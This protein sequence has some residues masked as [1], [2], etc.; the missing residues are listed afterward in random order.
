MGLGEAVLRRGDRRRSRLPLSGACLAG[1]RDRLLFNGDLWRRGGAP[2]RGAFADFLLRGI[3]DKFA[4]V[5]GTGA[6]FLSIKAVGEDLTL[7]AV[8]SVSGSDNIPFFCPMAEDG[9]ADASGC[10]DDA[11]KSERFL[12]F[13]RGV[14]RLD[15]SLFSTGA[16]SELVK[17]SRAGSYN[18][19]R[20]LDI[21]YSAQVN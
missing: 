19:P 7:F 3:A 18:D 11:V 2:L 13:P 1:E 6:T 20:L 16:S 17:T 9:D 15:C 5:I 10:G 8:G 4:A 14:L 21:S 12:L